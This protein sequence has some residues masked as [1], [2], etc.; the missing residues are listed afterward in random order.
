MNIMETKRAFWARVSYWF[1]FIIAPT[2]VLFF[3][4]GGFAANAMACLVAFVI[5]C[6]IGEHGF[7]HWKRLFRVE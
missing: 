5:L 4:L 2:V 3:L 1:L 7:R 6:V